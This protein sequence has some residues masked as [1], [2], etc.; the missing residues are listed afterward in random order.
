MVTGEGLL[1]WLVT[2]QVVGMAGHSCM[3]QQYAGGCL[4]SDGVLA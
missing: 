2:L 3:Q 4:R 1:W